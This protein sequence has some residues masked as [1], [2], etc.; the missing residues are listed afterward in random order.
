MVTA[1][2][3]DSR[4][5]AA[6]G[7]PGETNGVLGGPHSTSLTGVDILTGVEGLYNIDERASINGVNLKDHSNASN[8]LLSCWNERSVAHEDVEAG[9]TAITLPLARLNLS[10]LRSFAVL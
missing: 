4:P 3:N 9:S 1:Y 8:S 7:F 2:A 10:L 5:I 6:S